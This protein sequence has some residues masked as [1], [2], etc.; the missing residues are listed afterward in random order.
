M[1]AV[2]RFAT[3]G[4]IDLSAASVSELRSLAQQRPRDARL[5]VQ[6]ARRYLAEQRFPEAARAIGRG[7]EIDPDS[8]EALTLRGLLASFQHNPREAQG[9][10]ER[11]LAA[12][13]DY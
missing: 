12:K 3:E 1:A 9:A 7:L 8:A 11:A 13:P 10:F 6:L 2:G 5:P 4:S